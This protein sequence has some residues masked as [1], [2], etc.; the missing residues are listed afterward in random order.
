[1]IFILHFRLILTI[2]RVAFQ[3]S[4]LIKDKSRN[5]TC[6][7]P[8]KNRA[9][10]ENPCVGEVTIQI[11]HDGLNENWFQSFKMVHSHSSQSWGR[12]SDI[13]D[14]TFECLYDVQIKSFL[15]RGWL[16]A[17]MYENDGNISIW[18]LIARKF[19]LDI[20][21]QIMVLAG[22]ISRN[23]SCGT[24]FIITPRLEEGFP[25]I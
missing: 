9:P 19:T 5:I 17:Q 2:S 10:T 20:T 7:L 11:L 8:N 23:Y 3:A 13:Q 22:V 21:A 12:Y 14:S 16:T 24:I 25:V 6:A 4:A 18:I 15:W 1:M